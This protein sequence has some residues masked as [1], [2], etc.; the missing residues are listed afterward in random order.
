MIKIIDNFLS[1]SY[2]KDLQDHFLSLQCGWHYNDHLT[3]D[4]SYD[5]LGS[6]GF[7]TRLHWNQ[8]F[9]DS[10]CGILSKGL[11]LFSQA[12]VQEFTQI[13]YQIVRARADMTMYNPSK[14]CHEIP[15]LF[16]EI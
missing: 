9:V 1:E 16:Q 8:N 15:K 3:N 11:L 12:K 4:D 10:F 14:Y 7:T 5:N 2:L 13:P 6:F